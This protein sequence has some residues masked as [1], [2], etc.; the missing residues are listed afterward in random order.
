M[1]SAGLGLTDE[2]VWMVDGQLPM[3]YVN[4]ARIASYRDS[5]YFEY[6]NNAG[7]GEGTG[8]ILLASGSRFTFGFTAGLPV[9]RTVFNANNH[10]RGMFYDGEA[11]LTDRRLIDNNVYNALNTAIVNSN[12]LALAEST[13]I[14]GTTRNELKNRSVNVYAG[15]ELNKFSFAA[16][17]S[18]AYSKDIQGREKNSLSEELSLFKSQTAGALGVLWTPSVRFIRQVDFTVRQTFYYLNNVYDE[19]DLSSKNV[20]G[21]LTSSGSG[22]TELFSH[23]SF[24]ILSGHLFHTRF[25]VAFLNS[26]TQANARSQVS[27]GASLPFDY[28]ENYDRK[29]T[30]VIAG[31]SDEMRITKRIFWYC[32]FQ[33]EYESLTNEFDGKN[34]LTGALRTNPVRQNLTRL[35]I[36]ILAGLEGKISDSFLFRLGLTHSLKNLRSSGADFESYDSTTTEETRAANGTVTNTTIISRSGSANTSSAASFGISYVSGRFS[37]DWL[38]NIN[39]LREGPN[40]VSGKINDLS[41]AVGLAYRFDTSS[42]EEDAE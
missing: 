37:L 13:E 31:I 15:Y 40:F 5:F 9:N 8:G 28:S 24:P 17:L 23:A 32:G 3:I 6:R 19:N 42:S 33:M 4:P 20:V 38:A 16:E 2:F 29:G 21:S 25:S 22:D 26:S 11:T 12:G 27:N 35:Y 10:P 14:S 34:N 1:R 36:P 41:L 7:I 39:F 18:Y 30:R